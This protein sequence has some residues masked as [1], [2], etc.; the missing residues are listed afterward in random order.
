M[1]NLTLV[2]QQRNQRSRITEF[3]HH[4][5]LIGFDEFVIFDDHS[6]DGSLETLNNLKKDYNIK[7]FNTD[8]NVSN[9]FA[10]NALDARRN[11]NIYFGG[12]ITRLHNSIVNGILKSDGKF[13]CVLD[14][15]EFIIQNT[16]VRLLEFM[17]S[18]KP[19]NTS[20]VF[21]RSYDIKPEQDNLFDLSKALLKKDLVT[22]SNEVIENGIFRYRGK[23]IIETKNCK[24][25][26]NFGSFPHILDG[27]EYYVAQNS[28]SN[29]FYDE[30]LLQEWQKCVGYAEKDY[31]KILHFRE[32]PILDD[33][34]NMI[35]LKIENEWDNIIKVLKNKYEE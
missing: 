27:S 6:T 22:W 32:H 23:S 25:I 13:T 7:L 18:I 16:D 2:C 9:E 1:N 20:R 35:Q 31:F 17:E 30:L 26:N 11:N 15:D 29:V 10:H 24:T 34:Q 28:L 5:S 12:Y 14:I 19:K 3:I 4:H 8:L 21:I 33:Y